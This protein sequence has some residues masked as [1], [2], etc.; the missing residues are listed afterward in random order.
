M[1]DRALVLNSSLAEAWY[2]GGWAKIY[3]GE[4]E[5]ALERFARAMRLSPLGPWVVSLRAGIVHAHFL[6]GHYDEAVSWAAIALRDDPDHL[7]SL[8]IGA[9]SNAMAGRPGASAGGGSSAA[10]TASGVAHLQ[11]EGRARPLSAHRSL[12]IRGRVA[13]SRVARM[14]N[15]G[16]ATA[17]GAR[18]PVLCPS[19]KWCLRDATS[20]TH[21]LAHIGLFVPAMK[22]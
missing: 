19:Q 7:P 2:Y 14:R 6:L 15:R 11:S 13:K 18:L 10:A 1:I 20:K 12:A 17:R 21:R 16:R 8:R 22:R 4:P 9:A 3:L 5:A